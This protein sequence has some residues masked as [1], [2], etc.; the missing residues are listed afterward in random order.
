[1]LDSVGLPTTRDLGRDLLRA[2]TPLEAFEASTLAAPNASRMRS[3]EDEP[4][5]EQ[6]INVDESAVR[7]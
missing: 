5:P 4:R 2:A 1:M 3:D 7:V 6:V